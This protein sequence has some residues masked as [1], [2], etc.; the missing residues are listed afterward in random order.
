MSLSLEPEN[1]TALLLA[2]GWHEAIPGTLFFDAYE[3][4]DPNNE[5]ITGILFSG[6]LGFEFSEIVRPD[7]DPTQIA[8]PVSSILAIRHEP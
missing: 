5:K 3:F 1:V 4:I 8:G 7:A 2:D 6:G